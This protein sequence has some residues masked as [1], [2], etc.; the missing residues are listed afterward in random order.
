MLDVSKL[1]FFLIAAAVLIVVPG[2]SVFYIV[3]RS[4]DQGRLAGIVSTLGVSAGGLVHIAAAALGLSA[5]L[6][7]SALAFTTIKYLGAAYLIYLGLRQ[8]L[9]GAS[10]PTQSR[11]RKHQRL[12]RVFYEGALVNVLN[13]KTTLFFLAFLPQFVDPT[14]GSVSTQIMLLGIVFVSM[15]VVSD[16][17]YA[18]LAGSISSRIKA[19]IRFFSVQRAFG[20]GVY[21]A[22]GM[23][24]ALAQPGRGK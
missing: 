17:A 7:S 21:I 11:I 2:P 13:P 5:V 14:V 10:T 9:T 3:A 6:A 16:S 22:L 1:P 12:S 19:Q 20:G 15:A 24:T 18:F 4:V 23:M 8:L